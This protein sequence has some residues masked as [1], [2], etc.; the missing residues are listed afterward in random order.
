MPFTSKAQGRLMYA[1]ANNPKLAKQMG[2]PQK[3]AKE[4]TEKTPSMKR[5]PEKKK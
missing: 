4:M 2:I 3:V 5:L 1:V